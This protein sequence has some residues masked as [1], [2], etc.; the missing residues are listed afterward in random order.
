MRAVNFIVDG[1]SLNSSLDSNLEL[2]YFR[3]SKRK[4]ILACIKV[5]GR[6]L[7]SLL[8]IN[9]FDF[10]L[11]RIPHYMCCAMGVSNGKFRAL[12]C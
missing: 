6:L 3:L 5:T 11:R 9:T 10:S 4:E 2:T 7:H 12:D 8:N 1:D